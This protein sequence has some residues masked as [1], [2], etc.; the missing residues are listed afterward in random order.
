MA[1]V[2]LVVVTP[3]GPPRE[4]ITLLVAMVVGLIIFLGNTLFWKTSIRVASGVDAIVILVLVFGPAFVGLAPLMML[5]S[6]ARVEL[7]DHTPLQA[8]AGVVIGSAVAAS[9]FQV[10]Q[11]LVELKADRS[12]TTDR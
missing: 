7:S 4:L 5:V 8:T 6:W 1:L 3:L 10:L 9:V 11:K 2:G 12:L